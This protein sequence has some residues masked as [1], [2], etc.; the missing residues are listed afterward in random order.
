MIVPRSQIGTGIRTR[1][2]GQTRAKSLSDCYVRSRGIAERCE[3]REAQALPGADQNASTPQ[4][5]GKPRG[6]LGRSCCPLGVNPPDLTFR[7]DRMPPSGRNPSLARSF[8]IG[9]GSED[10]IPILPEGSTSALASDGLPNRFAAL[11]SRISPNRLPFSA[12]PSP[13]DR[14]KP[15]V[16]QCSS[17]VFAVQ[18]NISRTNQ[19]SYVRCRANGGVGRDQ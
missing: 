11:S 19:S 1:T 13:Y 14:L 3:A 4:N 18:Q 8:K 7:F 16:K 6:S 15:M 2:P 17:R 12:T 9:A 5:G 10:P